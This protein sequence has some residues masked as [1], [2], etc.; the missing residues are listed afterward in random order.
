MTICDVGSDHDVRPTHYMDEAENCDRI[1][2]IDQGEIVACG[3][4]EALKSDVGQ[5]RI[6]LHTDDDPAAIA[7]LADRFELTATMSE[8]AR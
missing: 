7:T 5:D 6:E 8:E 3:S 2:V 1:A 4:P